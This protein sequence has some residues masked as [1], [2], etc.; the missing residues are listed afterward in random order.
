MCSAPSRAITCG[1]GGPAGS[2]RE[3]LAGGAGVAVALP[4][5]P[6]AVTSTVNAHDHGDRD[7]N[8]EPAPPRFVLLT[9]GLVT[10]GAPC[11]LGRRHPRD[12][13]GP[14][15]GLQP[16]DGRG[17][18]ERLPPAGRPRPRRGRAPGRR[19]RRDSSPRPG[20]ARA[21]PTAGLPGSTIEGVNTPAGGRRG[22]R[23]RA[24]SS[25]SGCRCCILFGWVLATTAGHAVFLFIVAALIALLLDPIVRALG[26]LRIRRGL[27]VALVYS[28]FAAFV[29]VIVIAIGTVVVGQT[30]TAA[31]RFNDYFNATD[32]RTHQTAADRDVDRLQALARHAP[33]RIDQG[34][35]ARPPARAPDPRARRRQVHEPGRHVRRGRGGLDRQGRSSTPC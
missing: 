27:S 33:P 26:R 29:V 18:A 19:P 4:P 9:A 30:K 31:D 20:R 28:T 35:G 1:I 5:P 7:E 34:L 3:A 15:P 6:K 13:I 11:A 12:R 25:S 21:G 8:G 10:H 16:G 14:P 32:G 2:R 24:G 23:F 22:S 17:R